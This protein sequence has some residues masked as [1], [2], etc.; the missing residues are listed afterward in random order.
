MLGEGQL[1]GHIRLMSRIGTGGMGEVWEGVDERLGRRVAVKAIRRSEEANALARARFA[2]EARILSQLEHPNV[3]RLYEYLEGEEIDLLVLE[4]VRGRSLGKAIEAGLSASEKLGVAVGTCSALVAAHSLSVIHRDLKPDNVMLAE[5]GTV[6]VLD[7]GI[8]RRMLD[9]TERL[10]GGH[11]TL[12]AAPDGSAAETIDA[13]TVAGQVVGT[14]RYMSPEQAR[15][16]GATAASDMFSLGL[17]LFELYTGKAPY[18]SESLQQA[19]ARAQWGDVP[20]VTGIDRGVAALISDL[21]A[22]DPSKRLTAQQALERL[23]RIQHR[24][25]RRLRML[26]AAVAVVGLVT[27][28]VLSLVGL[29]QARREAAV[30]QASTDFLARL[31]LGSDPQEAPNPDIKARQVLERG[32]E[33][34][35][36]ELKDQPATR[37]RLLTVL[38]GIYGNLGLH[39][40]AQGLLEEALALQERLSG[41]DDAALV[42][43]LTRLG[44]A[45]AGQ[46]DHTRADALFRR[47][48]EIASREKVPAE[49]GAALNLLAASLHAQGRLDEAEPV[50]RRS[51]AAWTRA[52]GPDSAK[53]A[54]AMVNLALVE[55][56]RGRYASAEPI[57]VSVL[58]TLERHLGP[59]HP[60]VAS[61]VTNLA[62]VRKE[63][64]QLAEAEALTRRSLALAEKRLG[65]ENPQCA[66][67]RND[68]AVALFEQRR[69]AEAEEQYR[70]AVAIAEPALG[71]GHPLVAIF[72]SNLAETCLLQGR[73]AEAEPLYRR[74]LAAA[75]KAFG[76]QH[77]AVAEMLLGL[78]RTC[79]ALENAEDAEELLLRSISVREATSG[80]DHP[81]LGKALTKL[82][83]FYLDQGRP[84]AA[85]PV[86]E[87]ARV[88]LE[89]SLRPDHP[90]VVEL[91]AVTDRLVGASVTLAPPSA[92]R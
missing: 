4:L 12:A 18:E 20:P 40:Q 64:G 79:A 75:R 26:A 62:T 61:T 42:P 25:L 47:A 55:L 24:P 28:T 78:G 41:Q 44:N 39:T 38:G 57:L 6:K 58:A 74:A 32:V 37:A 66:V 27:G 76:E 92:A 91:R 67:V 83:A 60:D 11:A 2:R 51:V 69:Y 19:L 23:Q 88:I 52:V 9:P 1:V 8:A 63:L 86:L 5:D 15:G 36:T 49:E 81:E 70:R 21:T 90:A 71:A 72:T 84:E 17:L 43:V 87:R 14:P 29:R 50:A 82:G 13:L 89:A 22:L 73:P 34:V 65:P 16:E 7:F 53:T 33:R 30:A 77:P 35:R 56:N 54:G 80:Q 59:D 45:L 10:D 31:F 68:L 3:C 85:A 46:G 48:A